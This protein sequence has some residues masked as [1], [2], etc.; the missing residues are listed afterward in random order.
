MPVGIYVEHT[1]K[2]CL[3]WRINI[4]QGTILLL[5]YILDEEIAIFLIALLLIAR[6]VTTGD[7]EIIRDTL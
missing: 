7:M 5:N 4:N 6:N 3:P 2:S 1:R